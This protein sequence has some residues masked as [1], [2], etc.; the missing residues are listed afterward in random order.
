VLELDDVAEVGRA[1]SRHFV[2]LPRSAAV[3]GRRLFDGSVDFCWSTTGR[4]ERICHSYVLAPRPE[5]L[6]GVR[7]TVQECAESGAERVNCFIEA[8]V[9]HSSPLPTLTSRRSLDLADYRFG[10]RHLAT[11]RRQV[12]DADHHGCDSQH[13]A[14]Q[15]ELELEV[16]RLE[17]HDQHG[18]RSVGQ[19]AAMETAGWPPARG[20][21][22]RGLP[23]ALD[24]GV[25]DLAF[26][27][28]E[29]EEARVRSAMAPISASSSGRTDR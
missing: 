22:P 14:D 4:A 12:D 27:R 7:V 6:H 24:Q 19:M 26:V 8:A 25:G 13:Q 20:A 17:P 3:V 11:P 29:P 28:L 15:V 10:R 1:E 18:T 21:P 9:G 23:R 16:R 2:E 5:L